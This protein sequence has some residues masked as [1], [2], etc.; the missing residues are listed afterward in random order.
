MISK[1]FTKS[2][3]RLEQV[4]NVRS[5]RHQVIT[6]NIANQDT[7]GYKAKKL[8]FKE[9]LKAATSGNKPIRLNKTDKM[10]LRPQ[11]STASPISE[12]IKL[13]QSGGSKRLD[14]NTVKSEKEMTRLAENTLMYQAAAQLIAGKFRGLKNTIQEGR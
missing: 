8:D 9:A 13:S 12:Q 1:L 4:L 5:M 11:S 10:H 7:P 6:A 2:M 3:A 14:G